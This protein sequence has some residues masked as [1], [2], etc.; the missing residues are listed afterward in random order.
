MKQIKIVLA[1]LVFICL[2]T[3]LKANN[4]RLASNYSVENKSTTF[5]QERSFE[6]F[7]QQGKGWIKG[8]VYVSNG[9][10][11]RVAFPNFKASLN[12]RPTALNPNNPMA[13]QYNFTHFIDVPNTGRAYFILN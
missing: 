5:K 3:Q 13:T 7:V 6:A 2:S 9:S 12:L 4:I 8:V 11:T 1:L 10:V